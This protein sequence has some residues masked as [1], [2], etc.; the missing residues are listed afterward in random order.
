MSATIDKNV[1]APGET[2]HAILKVDNRSALEVTA[3]VELNRILRLKADGHKITEKQEYHLG[4]FDTI[5]PGEEKEVRMKFDIP[6]MLPT[7]DGRG[8]DCVYVLDV[9]SELQCA[10]DIE[11]HFP[12]NVFCAPILPETYVEDLGDISEYAI[13]GTCIVEDM[14]VKPGYEAPAAA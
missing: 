11:L 1:Y 7:T 8:V 12:I 13:A 5:A 10:P 2:A 9:V 14:P 4:R 6:N 3:M